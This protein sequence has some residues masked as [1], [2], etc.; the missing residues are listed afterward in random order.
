MLPI[1]P[2]REYVG[3]LCHQRKAVMRMPGLAGLVLLCIGVPVAGQSPAKPADSPTLK[4]SGYLQAREVYQTKVGIT[5]SSR[6][7][8]RRRVSTRMR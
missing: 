2:K 1:E 4:L 8:S 5:S 6:C 3:G 7:R